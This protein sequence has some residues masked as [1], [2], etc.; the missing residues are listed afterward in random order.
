MEFPLY[1]TCEYT[2][3]ALIDLGI[4]DSKADLT[5]ESDVYDTY[6]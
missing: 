5:Y 3:Q 4:I 6:G 2:I 1:D